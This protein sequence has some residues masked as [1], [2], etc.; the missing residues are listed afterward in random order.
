MYQQDFAQ[1][2]DNASLVMLLSNGDNAIFYT[3]TR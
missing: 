2:D 3:L 1:P